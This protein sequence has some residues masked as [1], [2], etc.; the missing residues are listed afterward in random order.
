MVKIILVSL[1]LISRC[2]HADLFD[3]G[4][5]SSNYRSK[6]PPLIEKLKS[7]KVTN[8]SAFDENFNEII[9]SIEAAVEEE[10]LYCLGE[11][12]NAQGKTLP[13]SQK[14]LCLG[15]LKQHYLDANEVIFEA[16]KRYLT[17]IHQ[18]QLDQ[19]GQIQ[20]KSRSDIEK[21]F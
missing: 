13:Q 5:K 1:F 2:A 10:K 14:K 11:A 7:L 12:I 17:A 19:L 15:E 8:D 20:K 3:F 21:S 16:K 6:L 9:K 18:W 4:S